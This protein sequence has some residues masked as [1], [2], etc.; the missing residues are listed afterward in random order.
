[1]SS[2]FHLSVLFLA[3]GVVS[4]TEMRSSDKKHAKPNI[5][6]ILADDLGW[7]DL[8]FRGNP[9]YETPHIDRLASEGIV[10]DNFYPSAANCAPSRAG[11]LT[12]MYAPR[13]HVYLPQ[14]CYVREGNVGN[15]RWKVPT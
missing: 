4:C 7:A 9:V 1:M 5:I 11:I 2:S 13:H 14:G 8:S 10:F 12:G 6:I 15:M 3:F